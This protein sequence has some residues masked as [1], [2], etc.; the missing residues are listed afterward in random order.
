MLRWR[1]FL[2]LS[3]MSYCVY[4]IHLDVCTT[5][6]HR[7]IIQFDDTLVGFVKTVSSVTIAC[8]AVASIISATIEMP[9]FKL[10]QLY[11]GRTV[12]RYYDNN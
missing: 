10:E 5:L 8:F 3:R 1:G 9:L 4:L 2:P 6:H 12:T 7:Q 11:F